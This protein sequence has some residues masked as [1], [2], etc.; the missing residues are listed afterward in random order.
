ML[1]FEKIF[2]TI[3]ICLDSRIYSLQ[4]L[5]SSSSSSSTSSSSTSSPTRR[6]RLK[7]EEVVKVPIFHTFSRFQSLVSFPRITGA[8][9]EGLS[10]LTFPPAASLWGK[11][12][13]FWDIV[14][15][16]SHE[17]GSER[18]RGRERSEQSGASEQVSGASERANGRASG[19]VLTSQ[20]LAVLPHCAPTSPFRTLSKCLS[21]VC[22]SSVS[23]WKVCHSL[24]IFSCLSPSDSFCLVT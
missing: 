10:L 15:I 3:I 11:F 1:L 2:I 18:S 17:R 7:I 9:A 8:K 5:S 23:R 22:L 6:A 4:P 12:R 16:L 13:S 14:N 24:F 20:F 21:S 19:Q